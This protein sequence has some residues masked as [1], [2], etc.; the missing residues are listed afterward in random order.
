LRNDI[1]LSLGAITF[2]DRS[3]EDI[4]SSAHRAGFNGIGLTVGQCV[5]ALE[6]G[7]EMSQII[8]KVEDAG[9][10]IAEFELVR[11]G[12]QPLTSALNELV[13]DLVGA[14]APDRVHVAA[15]AG[16]LDRVLK[17][18]T[19]LCGRVECPVAFEFM[20]YSVVTNLAAA[21]ELVARTGA[22]NAKVVLDVLHYFRSGSHVEDLTDDDMQDVAV[23]QLSDVTSRRRQTEL[24][25]EARHLR[26]YPGQGEL[27]IVNFLRRIGSFGALPPITIE[28]IS[29]ALERMPLVLVAEQA[30]ISTTQV[31]RLAGF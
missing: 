26:T 28:P 21:R 12:G 25:H 3:F 1:E 24:S 4:V 27:P 15:F 10:H 16:D 9:L 2:R 7:V 14:L 19:A 17:E 23:V 31:L 6:R 13:I 29:D 22:S 8:S 20:P 18:F 30:M 11:L 5:S